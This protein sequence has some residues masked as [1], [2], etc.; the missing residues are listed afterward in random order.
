MHSLENTSWCFYAHFNI[1]F[2]FIQK[3]YLGGF[4]SLKVNK[5]SQ[6]EK[7]FCCSL[8][9]KGMETFAEML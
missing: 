3:K 4:F 2:F 5:A 8:L 1:I 7:L 6:I 9:Q